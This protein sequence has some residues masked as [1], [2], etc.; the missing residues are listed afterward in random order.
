MRSAVVF[1][2]VGL[3]RIS[4]AQESA[5]VMLRLHPHVGD[6]LHT[7]LEQQTDV[8]AVMSG[9]TR[10]VTTSIA[11]HS[12]TIVRSVQQLSTTV[13]TI[14]D[15]AKL[16]STDAHASKMIAD[17]QRALQ[18]QRLTLQLGADG[19]VESARDA[20]GDL[21]PRDVA[22]ALASMPAVFPRRPVSVGQEWMREMPLPAGGPLGARGSGHVRAVFHLDSLQKSGGVAYVS[23]HGDI[24]P[25][26]AS[27]GTE[28]SG[29]IAGSMQL[30]RV[31]GW[32]TDSRIVITLKSLIAAPPSV[33][34][35]PMKVVTRVTQ[36]LR[37]M[38]KR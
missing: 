34:L 27:R 28:L 24:L 14:V 25:D 11:V 17:A 3:A 7:W 37:T 10:S 32:M 18:G 9:V 38:D 12:R 4:H 36:R 22:D 35:A 31:R 19:T 13:V 23:M 5:Q 30:D 29:S 6:T 21:V 2:L 20:R 8:S 15:S 26:S 1:A 33:G 16:T